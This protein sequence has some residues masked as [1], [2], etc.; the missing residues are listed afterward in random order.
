MAQSPKSHIALPASDSY[1]QLIDTVG[2]DRL[3]CNLTILM[4]ATS[5]GR[6][7][8]DKDGSWEHE[9]HSES[10]TYHLFGGV[11]LI[12]ASGGNEGRRDDG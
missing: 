5:Y 6:E 12:R 2:F 10:C 1:R 4:S 3:R 8:E 9:I 11:L 7:P